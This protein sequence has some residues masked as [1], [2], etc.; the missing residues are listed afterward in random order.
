MLKVAD[1]ATP[2]EVMQSSTRKKTIL[3]WRK[4]R[5]L[6]RVELGMVKEERSM[7]NKRNQGGPSLEPTSLATPG[8]TT[9][10]GIR[11]C[12]EERRFFHERTDGPSTSKGTFNMNWRL[13]Y[14]VNEN[15]CLAMRKFLDRLKE[16]FISDRIESLKQ[17][18]LAFT[19]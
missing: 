15:A 6:N 12:H 9:C 10:P 11:D 16:I 5:V 19:L 8:T 3:R 2:V 17:R 13:V 1:L 18:Q 4:Q 14:G 7:L